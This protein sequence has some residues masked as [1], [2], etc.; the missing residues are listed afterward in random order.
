MFLLLPQNFMC[1]FLSSTSV[2]KWACQNILGEKLTIGIQRI[3]LT[4][5][6]AAQIFWNLS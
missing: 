2:V 1:A 4:Q 3:Q 5:L 6:C